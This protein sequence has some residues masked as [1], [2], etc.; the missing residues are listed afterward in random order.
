MHTEPWNLLMEMKAKFPEYFYKKKVLEAG[1]L[2]ING[3]VRGFFTACWYTGVDVGAG[4]GVDLVSPI[5]E[6]VATEEFDVVVS[7]EMLEHDQH[8]QLSLKRMYDNLKPGGLFIFSCA[9]PTRQEHGTKRTTPGD[10]PYT[11]D[12]YRNISIEDFR[13]ILPEEFFSESSIYYLRNQADL[14]FWGKKK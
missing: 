13:S 5:H 2:D 10:S 9:G 14:L 4:K 6:V 12:Y 8:W 1:S 11:T 3:S 7:T